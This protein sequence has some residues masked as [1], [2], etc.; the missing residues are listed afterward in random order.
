MKRFNKL[1]DLSARALTALLLG[2]SIALTMLKALEIPFSLITVMGLCAGLVAVMTLARFNRWTLCG[3]LLAL[4]AGLAIFE[5]RGG[6]LLTSLRQTAS[7]LMRLLLSGEGVL[8][9]HATALIVSI[10]LLSAF[11]A[12]LFS[13]MHGGVYPAFLLFLFVLM[14]CWFLRGELN[15]W[16]LL[17]G[18]VALALLYARSYKDS[19]A[20]LRA[21][22][23]ALCAALLTVLLLPRQQL[24][25]EPL[26]EAADKV[27]KVFY[28]YFLFTDPRAVYSVASDGYQPL[29]E[30]LGGPANPHE[31]EIMQVTTD[32]N[33]LLRGSVKRTYTGSS[34]VDSTVNSRYLFIDP[35]RQGKLTRIF[36]LDKLGPLEGCFEKDEVQ[37]ELLTAGTSTLFVSSRLQSLSISLD[38]AAYFN[39]A[40]EVFIARGVEPG[41]EYSFTACR[42]TEELATLT[43]RFDAA[44]ALGDSDY[45]AIR[46]EYMNLPNTLEDEVYWT[47]LSVIEGLESPLEKALAIERYLRTHYAYSTEVPYTPAGRDF[48]SYFLLDS[49]KGYC[50]YFA[51]AMAVMAR[52]ADLPCRY[53]EGY[54]VKAQPEGVTL[55]RGSDAHAWVEIYFEG[56]GWVSFDPTPGQEESPDNQAGNAAPDP[57]PTPTP[58]PTPTPAPEDAPP[59]SSDATPTP[60]PNNEPDATPSPEPDGLITPTPEPDNEPPQPDNRK[61]NHVWLWILLAICLLAALGCL[62]ARRARRTR[63]EY[64]VSGEGD[65]TVQ[66][67]IW[68]RA[69]LSLLA[70]ESIEPQGGETPLAFAGRLV[71][72]NEAPAAFLD[73]ARAVSYASYSAQPPEE[74][75]LMQAAR[76]YRTLEAQQKKTVRMRYLAHRMLHGIG[77]YRQIP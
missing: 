3:S 2:V 54:L 76:I 39:D 25:W 5:M 48:V 14:G 23:L 17:P 45:D 67:M 4:A 53:V 42:L 50:T 60:E 36:N 49:G 6:Q 68:Y 12:F 20:S 41:D 37:V 32:E 33:L 18:L 75:V 21:L 30:T 8:A 9:D 28:D 31:N 66:L 44:A 74:R 26:V 7:E 57:S 69:I 56:I 24:T 40:G 72:G 51:S 38:Q 62:A 59:Q 13:K 46:S 73:V 61:K 77:N 70:F 63:P 1:A 29:G 71:A 16:Q 15:P 43:A 19:P 65:K 52:L 55:V 22:P 11:I 64:L 10:S 35:T 47:T 34:W 27:R 58:E